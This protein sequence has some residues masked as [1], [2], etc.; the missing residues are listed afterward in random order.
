MLFKPCPRKCS[1]PNPRRKGLT[2]MTRLVLVSVT[3]HVVGKTFNNDP[4]S[5]TLIDDA[6]LVDKYAAALLHFQHASCDDVMNEI[7]CHFKWK[8]ST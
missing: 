1:F 3:D 8:Y 4:V 5:M 6:M 2:F 7:L